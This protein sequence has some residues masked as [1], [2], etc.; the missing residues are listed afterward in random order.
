DEAPAGPVELGAVGVPGEG[1]A[2]QGPVGPVAPAVIGTQELDG[3]ALVVAADLHAA[4]AARVEIYVDAARGVPAEDDRLLPHGRDEKVARPRDLALVAE[5]EPGAGEHALE[6]LPVDLV[7]DEDLAADDPP[8]DV[9]QGSEASEIRVEH[10][11]ALPCR[12][13]RRRADHSATR[14]EP[15]AGT[16]AI[17]FARSTRPSPRSRAAQLELPRC[18]RPGSPQRIP[19]YASGCQGARASSGSQLAPVPM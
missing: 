18:E 7:A 4:V 3:I 17:C 19:T 8:V 10:G 1:H 2:H 9:D 15:Q 5:E 14:T 11:H 12:R 13:L 16:G 6:L